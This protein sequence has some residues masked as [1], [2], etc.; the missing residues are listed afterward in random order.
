VAA[1]VVTHEHNDHAAH[2]EA[3][4]R[5]LTCPVYLHHGIAAPRVR[6]RF[7]V[8]GYDVR[9]S[10]TVGTLTVDALVVPHD[11]PHVAL[12]VSS[13]DRAF[14][15]VT[16]LGH[17]PRD[18]ATFVGACD[19]ALVEANYCPELLATG[20]YPE[21]L[22]RRVAGPLGHLANAQTAEL[23]R[24][25]RGTRLV[26]LYLGHISRAN[27]TPERALAE[28]RRSSGTLDVRVVPNGTPRLLDVPA[29]RR[30]PTEQLALAFC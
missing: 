9:T 21:R 17:V 20:P 2:T 18:L 26:R 15:V 13:R 12:R 16:D 8:R 19:A 25:L 29:G 3:L 24:A 7:E 4:A 28:V 6:S 22:R 1:L 10:F 14:A 5:Q 30:V 27:N 11:A 23:A